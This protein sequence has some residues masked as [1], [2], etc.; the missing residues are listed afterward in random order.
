MLDTDIVSIDDSLFNMGL[1]SL[2]A[3]KFSVAAHK[4][5]EFILIPRIYISMILFVL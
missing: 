2:M 1:D 3:I 5:L 4:V